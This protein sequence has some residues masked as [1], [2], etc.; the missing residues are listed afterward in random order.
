MHP[1][2]LNN[3]IWLFISGLLEGYPRVMALNSMTGPGRGA[4]PEPARPSASIA[5]AQS[6]WRE[7][8]GRKILT[9]PR[10]D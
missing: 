5:H 2:A 1:L 8:E 9:L 3:M 7:L 6:A 4:A 10:S